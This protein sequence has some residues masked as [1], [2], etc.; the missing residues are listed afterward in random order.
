MNKKMLFPLLCLTGFNLL[1]ADVILVQQKYRFYILNQNINIPN[2]IVTVGEIQQLVKKQLGY[3]LYIDIQDLSPN[4]KFVFKPG[5]YKLGNVLDK[6]TEGIDSVIDVNDKRQYIKIEYPDYAYIDL[7]YDWNMMK[8]K[9]SFQNL[10]PYVHF[11]VAGNRLTAAGLSSDLAGL[12]PVMKAYQENAFK[13]QRF[14][15]NIY[16]YC[17]TVQNDFF[18]GRRKYEGSEQ[19][20]P[21]KSYTVTVMHGDK[22]NISYGTMQVNLTYDRQD[23][24]IYLYDLKI[25]IKDLSKIGFVFKLHKKRDR[26]IFENWFGEKKGSQCNDAI[27]TIDPAGNTIAF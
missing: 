12:V 13:K 9:K 4:Q 7:P 5:S 25:P 17:T 3:D 20:K 1:H 2:E 23:K 26:N 22:I 21:L 24:T 18:I 10:F 16:P 11:Y 15:I 8:A 6:I 19:Y 14:F 27:I